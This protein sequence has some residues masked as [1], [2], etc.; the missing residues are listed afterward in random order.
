MD[1]PVMSTAISAKISAALTPVFAVWTM[2]DIAAVSWNILLLM[3]GLGALILVHEFGH[4]IVARMCGVRCEKFYIGFDF[5]GLKLCKFKWGDTE[6]GV[7]V[8]PLGGYVKMLGQE[9]NPGELRAEMERAKTQ[10]Q[11]RAG[12]A[13]LTESSDTEEAPASDRSIEELSEQLYAPDSYLAKSV[14]Q[15]LAIICAGVAMNFLFAIVCATGAYMYGFEDTAAAI[16]GI[17]PGSPAWSAGL[18]VG[19]QIETINDKPVRVFTDMN[20]EMVGNENGVTLS[21]ERDGQQI[22]KTVK[23]RKRKTDLAPTMGVTSLPTL[24]LALPAK[25]DPEFSPVYKN[26]KKYYA[27]E[28]LLALNKPNLKIYGVNGTP[29]PQYAD[30]LDVLHQ[31]FDK[32]VKAEVVLQ[33]PTPNGP[34]VDQAPS[35]VTIPAIPMKEI[36]VR[37]QPGEITMVLPGSD[38][39]KKGIVA[40]DTI[41]SV[42]GDTEYDPLKLPQYI[43]G[44][45][46]AGELSVELGLKTVDGTEKIV[47]V[48]LAPVRILPTLSAMSMKDPV[49]STALG[50]SWEVQPIIAGTIP[51]SEAE[52]L[53]IPPGSTVLSV[54][55]LNSDAFFSKNTSFTEVTKEGYK[56]HEV[57]ILIDIPYIFEVLLPSAQPK[58]LAKKEKAAGDKDGHVEKTVNVRLELRTP[59]G[60]I[61]NVNLPIVDSKDRFNMDRGLIFQVERA[62]V[63]IENFGEAL[64]AGTAKMVD[65][66]FAVLR[67]LEQLFGGGVSPRALGGPVMIVQVAFDFVQKGF[68]SYLLFLCLIGANLAVINILPIP[69]LDGGHVVFLLYEGITGHAPN[70][71]VQVVLSYLGLLAILALMIWVVALDLNWIARF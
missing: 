38:A 54:T 18:E 46:N 34:P 14:P 28:D 64:A 2:A 67:T 61:Q 60:N 47:T 25:P 32:P 44:K 50:L 45:V 13:A 55:F 48:E 57:G 24:E 31:N 71:T 21:I 35:E 3:V 19:D 23:P 49:G 17:V 22:E 30:F 68:G 52:K 66:S 16:G 20:M 27:S 33:S 7:G 36:G 39:E 6:Y 41:L 40:G 53:E 43:L 51:G 62:E 15:R 29:M 42:D 26:V 5:W 69:V 37:F 70:E 58:P 10:A 12:D 1:F 9:D 4:F 11:A 65:S 63:K 59:D 56:L 8:F